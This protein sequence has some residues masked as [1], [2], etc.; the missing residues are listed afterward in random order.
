MTNGEIILY[1]T[2]DGEANI[3]LQAEDVL[4]NAGKIKADVA[5]KLALDRFSQ[6][7][8]ARIEADREKA[9]EE[10]IAE[11]EKLGNWQEMDDFIEKTFEIAVLSD[12]T[13]FV[14]AP[15]DAALLGQ[16][17]PPP[18]PRGRGAGPHRRRLPR[19]AN[20][21]P[22]AELGRE[23]PPGLVP[24]IGPTS[25]SPHAPCAMGPVRLRRRRQAEALR[26]K[27][28]AA[29]GQPIRARRAHAQPQ[30]DPGPSR[31]HRI[32]NMPRAL[33]FEAPRPRPRFPFPPGAHDVRL[34]R[35]QAVL[36]EDITT[37]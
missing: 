9:D 1:A 23:K 36:G 7:E 25:P 6:Y 28:E 30:P 21:G 17:T 11:I 13:I 3:R 35:A 10:D 32:R 5:E 33:P 16:T 12:S 24:G 15:M 26:E 31:L 27:A 18:N 8:T 20:A 4:K 29:L 34:A 14:S 2:E 22:G 19:G 37:E